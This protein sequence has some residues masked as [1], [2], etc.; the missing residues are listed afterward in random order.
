[1]KKLMVFEYLSHKR[2]PY[3]QLS[4]DRTRYVYFD[5]I[6]NLIKYDVNRITKNEWSNPLD[7]ATASK[8]ANT[9]AKTNYNITIC[10]YCYSSSTEVYLAAFACNGYM[11]DV[12]YTHPIWFKK[13]F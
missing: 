12:E 5:P 8:I 1:M 2:I 11:G 4:H 10:T 13:T 3:F 6:T 7:F 9:L